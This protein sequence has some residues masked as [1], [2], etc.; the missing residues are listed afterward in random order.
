MKL[1][2][3][4]LSGIAMA[5]APVL[6]HHSY[7]AFDMKK[8]ITIEGVVVSYQLINPHVHMTVKVPPGAKDPSQVGVWD[9]EGAAANI[10]RRQGWN[11][12]TYKAGDPIILVG[13]PLKTGDKGIALSYALQPDGKQLYMDISRPKEAVGK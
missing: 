3:L 2:T 10:M 13:N 12:K 11:A 5:A 8:F 4:L 1:R 6:A 7:A 9:V